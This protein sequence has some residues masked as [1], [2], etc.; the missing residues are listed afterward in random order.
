[1][2]RMPGKWRFCR[3]TAAGWLAVLLLVAVCTQAR[4]FQIYRQP[5]Q[6]L[7]QGPLV[8]EPGLT[9]YP[10][11]S[12]VELLRDPGGRLTPQQAMSEELQWDYKPLNEVDTDLENVPTT[13][14]A[15]FTLSLDVISPPTRWTLLLQDD[16]FNSKQQEIYY[17]FRD[18]TGGV[19]QGA[20]EPDIMLPQA[21]ST[22]V[23][24]VPVPPPGTP[25]TGS[26]T[27]YV[28]Y[29]CI[30][31]RIPGFTLMDTFEFMRRQQHRSLM[32]GLY[33]G[34]LLA[35]AVV[36]LTFYIVVRERSLLYFLFW[37]LSVVFFFAIKNSTFDELLLSMSFWR[38]ALIF[39]TSA[40]LMLFCFSLFSRAFLLAKVYSKRADKMLSLYGYASLLFIP[41]PLFRNFELYFLLMQAMV[42]VSPFLFILA[43]VLCLHKGFKSARFFIIALAPFPIGGSLQ[44]LVH[45]RYIPETALF[46]HGT[47]IGAGLL[48]LLLSLALADRMRALRQAKEA[49]ESA[50]RESE[51]RFRAIFDQTFQYIAL[52]DTDGRVLEVNRAALEADHMDRPTNV[53]KYIWQRSEMLQAGHGDKL[54]DAIREAGAGRF[55]RFEQSFADSSGRA[56]KHFDL[57]IK[58]V[59]NPEGKVTLLI[60][61]ARDISELKAAQERVFQSEKFSAL[62]RIVAGVAHEINNPNNFIYFNI[63]VLRDYLDAMAPVLEKC[64]EAEGSLTIM[65]QP[66]ESYLNDMYQLLDDMELGSSRIASIV[67]E[68]KNYLRNTENDAKRDIRIDEII[69]NVMT[70]AGNQ[71][72]KMVKSLDVVVTPDLPLLRI[73][74]A[75]IEQ[76]LINLLVNAGQAADKSDSW[77]KLSVEPAEGDREGVCVHI[78]DNGVGIAEELKDKVFEPF[79]TTKRGQKGTG[80]GLA[81]SRN[82]IVEHGGELRLRSHLGMGTVFSLFLPVAPE[83]ATKQKE[84]D[85]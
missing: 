31:G 51:L 57:S 35:V 5:E 41:L 74:P 30:G 33:Y 22:I 69:D 61:E 2:R 10:L 36:V 65:N 55:V 70:L 40:G 3:L 83:S 72:R 59:F 47:Q 84:P 54:K 68:L 1:M 23:I 19:V 58:P 60:A 17:R 43:G 78:E 52:L 21:D 73:N 11:S 39:S 44:M 37:L 32:Y 85:K 50:R 77:V 8:L 64:Q 48:T 20:L 29:S 12:H 18:F 56:S 49:A 27:Y 13:F 82:I 9:S 15:R 14:W 76:V 7:F 26:W 46:A 38:Q 81:I 67:S 71:V 6:P 4:A 42:L 24:I 25:I 80:Q 79:F 53:G 34:F 28:R 45:M 66:L 75:R 62:G 63:P 16:F